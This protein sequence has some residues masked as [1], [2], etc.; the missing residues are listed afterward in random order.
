MDTQKLLLDENKL[1]TL[2]EK[3]KGYMTEKRYRHTLAVEREVCRLAEIFVPDEPYTALKLRCAALLHDIT[4]VL[5]LEKQLQYCQIFDIIIRNGDELS[6]KIFH[7]KTGA[8]IAKRDFSEYVDGEILSGIRW[9]TTGR[10]AMTLF[11]CIVYLADYIEDTRTFE[12]CVLLREYFYSEVN[13]PCAD[14]ELV[15]TKTMVLSFDMTI[16]CLLSENALVDMDTIE[17]RNYFIR[18]IKK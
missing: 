18:K 7:A 4:K 14:K 15:L 11:E 16:K 6:P 3:V 12:D 2:R 5:S 9:H 8:E 17:A 13:D 10:D 1:C